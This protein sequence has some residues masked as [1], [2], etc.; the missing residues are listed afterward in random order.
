MH[1]IPY[2]SWPSPISAAATTRAGTRFSDVVRIDGDDIYWIE[3]RPS[4][5]G[6]NVIVRSAQGGPPEDIIGSEWNARTRVHEYGGGTYA[7]HMGVV[8]F[9]SFSDQRVYRI[10]PGGEPEPITPA[11]PLPAAVRYADFVVN[12]DRLLCVRETHTAGAEPVNELVSLPADGVGDATVIATGRDF[13]ASPRASPDATAIAWLAWDHPNMPWDGTELWLASLDGSGAQRVMG[14]PQ[15]ALVQPE[16]SPDGTLHVLSDRTGWWS[17]HRCGE[18]DPIVRFDEE[19]GFPHW[20]FG[21]SRYAFTS[22]G[23]IVAATIGRTHDRLVVISPDGTFREVAHPDAPILGSQ[24]ALSGDS[25]ITLAGGPR[26]PTELVAFSL[27]DGAQRLIRAADPLG[28]DEAFL[29]EPVEL[30]FDTPQGDAYA[31]LYPPTHPQVKPPP[32]ALAPLIVEIH[33]GPTGQSR[34]GVSAE[35]AFWT[36]R[37]FA[38]LDV[39]YSGSTGFGTAFRRRLNGNWGVVDVR[40]CGLAAAAAAE[41]GFAD[42]D[43]LVIRGGSAGGFTALASMAF[44]DE[45]A[46]ATSYFGIADLALLTEHTHKFESH[47]DESLIGRYPEDADTYRARSPIHHLDRIDRPVLLFQGLD[48]LVVPAEQARVMFEGLKGQGVPVGLIEYEGEGHGFRRAENQIRTVEAEL[49]F[50]GHVLGFEPADDVQPV[51]GFG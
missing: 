12:G 20:V 40:D 29:P 34:P 36:S 22:E 32:D 24:L 49:W 26:R 46:A 11:P 44:R 21:G 35:R 17:I 5:G 19:I 41:R 50:Y 7:A 45:F 15:E 13:Y 18:S 38:V 30:T 51:E 1:T 31:T 2:G 28:F 42:P 23:T 3:S 27:D 25:V 6:R 16:W 9:S 4:E 43:R 39:N 47:Y 8:W 10:L 48:D 33:G 37:G 14:E